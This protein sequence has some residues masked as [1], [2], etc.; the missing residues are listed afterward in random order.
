M[1]QTLPLVSLTEPGDAVLWLWEAHN[2]VNARL[3]REGGG[4]PV[5]PKHLF[6]SIS[7][8]PYC[9]Q[10]KPLSPDLGGVAPNF[11]NT[12]FAAGE[13]LLGGVAGAGHHVVGTPREPRSVLRARQLKGMPVEYVWNR[14]AVLLYLW[15]F[16][17]LE[18]KP[19]QNGTHAGMEPGQRQVRVPPLAVLQAAWPSKY[20]QPYKRAYVSRRGQSEQ[21]EVCLTWYVVCVLCLSLLVFWLYR[22]RKFRYWLFRY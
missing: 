8:C 18:L 22:R 7:R 15:N 3:G 10:R 4:D 5:Y 14:T 17:H 21:G 11:N 19:A 1:S 12:E 13:S 16:Y 20:E 9:Y 2:T 6:P